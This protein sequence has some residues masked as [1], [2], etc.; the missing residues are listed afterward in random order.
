MDMNYGGDVGGRA[1]AR[2]S[3]VKGGKWDN[4]NSIINKYILKIWVLIPIMSHY[5][6]HTHRSH[7][8]PFVIFFPPILTLNLE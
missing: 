1:C 7:K 3:G 8:S 2:W 6:L 5:M 4:H